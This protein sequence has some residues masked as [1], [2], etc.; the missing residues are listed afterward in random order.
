MFVLDWIWIAFGE[1][2]LG[3]FIERRMEKQFGLSREEMEAVLDPKLYTGRC[4]E[5]VTRFVDK[6][7][8]LLE[9]IQETTAEINL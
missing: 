2:S 6:V 7:R 8:P 4:A 9:G 1:I 5:Q 3:R